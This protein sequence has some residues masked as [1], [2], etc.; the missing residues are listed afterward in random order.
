MPNWI[1]DTLSGLRADTSK[2]YRICSSIWQQSCE[3]TAFREE[4]QSTFFK[5]MGLYCYTSGRMDRQKN[6]L[7]WH[8]LRN[9]PN[10]NRTCLT[11]R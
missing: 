10:W 3:R 2:K 5:R 8:G 6:F 9:I 11:W 1:L 4:G 7:Q